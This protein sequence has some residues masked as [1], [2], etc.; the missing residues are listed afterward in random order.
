MFWEKVA[1]QELLSGTM[2]LTPLV[3]DASPP[4]AKCPAFTESSM[5]LP[6]FATERHAGPGLGKASG[7]DYMVEHWLACYAMLYLS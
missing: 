1:D 6:Y 7:T 2:E 5:D 3:T 4:V